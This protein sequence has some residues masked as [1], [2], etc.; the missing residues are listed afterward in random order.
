MLKT[1]I[2]QL[3]QREPKFDKLYNH[4]TAISPFVLAFSGG[5][6][7]TLL[8]AICSTLKKATDCRAITIVTP[9]IAKWEL[10]EAIDYG[11]SLNFKH[12]VVTMAIPELIKNNPKLRCYYCKNALMTEIINSAKQQD[13]ETIIDGTNYDDLSDYR[14]GLKALRE[15]GIISP[16]L[17]CQITKNEI[18][19]WS[20]FLKLKTWDKPAY[21]CLLTRLETDK[22]I[23]EA[24]L[25]L[26]EAAEMFLFSLGI[27]DVRVRKHERLARIEVPED[28]L[29]VV[30]KQRSVIVEGLAELGFD[31]VT[32][33]MV[34]YRMSG[35]Q[36]LERKRR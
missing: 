17:E 29:Q 20:K 24:D 14:P 36:H 31:Y 26:I 7:S 34:G 4:L 6:D 16:F 10:K 19:Q 8:L 13:I 15:N 1:A 22:P 21:A 9:Y 35:L 3:R 5:V 30:F 2:D 18:R 27:R 11:N 25:N 12:D 23:A 33:D 32:L 28:I